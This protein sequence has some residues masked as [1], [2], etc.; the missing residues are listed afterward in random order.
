M[1]DIDAAAV[2]VRLEYGPVRITSE[3]TVFIW[4]IPDP[5]W[6]QIGTAFHLLDGD[7]CFHMRFEPVGYR[8]ELNVDTCDSEFGSR[9]ENTDHIDRYV[10]RD[11]RFI[12]ACCRPGCMKEE[13][14]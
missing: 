6:K 4:D 2:K 1:A 8:W 14:R 12:D 5:S 9:W 3:P 10:H 11:A 7:H 13:T